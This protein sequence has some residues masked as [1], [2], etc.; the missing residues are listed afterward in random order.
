MLVCL[1]KAADKHVPSEEMKKKNCL[2]HFTGFFNLVI[3]CQVLMIYSQ[4]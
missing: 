1:T 2:S 3:H 4:H